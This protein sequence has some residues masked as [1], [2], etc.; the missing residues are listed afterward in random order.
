MFSPSV[1]TPSTCEEFKTP[2][3]MCYPHNNWNDLHYINW[4]VKNYTGGVH[5]GQLTRYKHHGRMKLTPPVLFWHHRC[6]FDTAGVILTPQ[7]LQG[8][9]FTHDVIKTSKFLYKRLPNWRWFW[10]P[11]DDLTSSLLREKR[12]TFQNLPSKFYEKRTLF[13]NSIHINLV[14][15][16]GSY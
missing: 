16:T 3:Q 11:E 15:V 5:I 1:N 12:K 13:P 8:N 9:H 14:L 2:D 10:H 7:V 4:G 6:Y